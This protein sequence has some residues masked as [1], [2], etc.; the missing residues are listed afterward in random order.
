MLVPVRH[1]LRT[2]VVGLLPVLLLAG[3]L[4][5]TTAPPA[6]AAIEDFARYQPEEKCSPKAKPG[7]AYLSGWLVRKYDGVRGRV[8]AACTK[9]ISEH[10]EGRAIDW[11]ND[12]TTK[13]GRKRVKTFLKDVL[14]EDHRERPAAKARRM[15][16]IHV[17]VLNGVVQV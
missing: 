3:A 5:V 14:A 17:T 9:S 8:G 13:A 15:G 6:G 10:Q 2:L 16:I 12:A 11:S 4:T 1:A 7:A